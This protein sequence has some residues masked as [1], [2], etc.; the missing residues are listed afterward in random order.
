[1]AKPPACRSPRRNPPLT[2]KDELAGAAPEPAPTKGSDTSTLAPA[3]SCVPTPTPPPDTLVAAPSSAPALAATAPSSDNELFKQFMKAYLEAQVPGRTEVDPEPREQPLKAR[4]PDLY[5]GN[6][7]MDCYQF[8]QQCEDHFKTAGAKRSNRILFAALF[9]RKSVT[10]RWFQHKQRRNGAIP[11]TWPEFK[12][13]FQKN[14]GDSRAF[15]DSVWKKVKRDSQYQDKSVQDW[16]AHLEYLQSI[17][18][19]FNSK[20]APKE[21][22]MFRYLREGLCPSVRV[23]IEQRGRQLD[24]FEE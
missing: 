8:C 5:Y 24:N 4:F 6:S 12:E 19:E 13:F 9:L 10:R 17:L 20:W 23:K 22:M 2:G 21:G 18:I 14:L 3:A 16:A 15:V 1:M 11:M 7:H